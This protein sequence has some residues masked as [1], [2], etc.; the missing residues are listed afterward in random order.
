MGPG[1]GNGHPGGSLQHQGSGG[2]EDEREDGSGSASVSY[3]ARRGSMTDVM[4]HELAVGC[5][6][7][8]ALVV[9]GETAVEV[10]LVL[11]HELRRARLRERLGQG[12]VGPMEEIVARVRFFTL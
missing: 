11:E 3:A 8:L 7:R 5:L 10:G 6:V 12:V 2:G 1:S 4:A 9:E